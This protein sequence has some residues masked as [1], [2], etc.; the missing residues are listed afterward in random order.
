MSEVAVK[1][2][3]FERAKRRA[4]PSSNPNAAFNAALAAAR[5]EFPD[6]PKTRVAEIRM[7]NGGKYS[8]KYADLADVFNAINPVLAANGLSVWQEPQGLEIVTTIL[9]ESGTE[10]S[11]KWPIKAMPQRGLDDAQSFQSAVQVAKRYA[12]TATLGIT[13]E[14]TVEGDPMAKRRKV[15]VELDD[16]FQTVDGV[17]FPQGGKYDPKKTARQ[18]AEEA[19]RAIIALFADPKTQ[20]G[21]NGVWNRN[22]VFVEKMR[23]N[24]PDLYN[25]VFEAYQE[26]MALRSDDPEAANGFTMGQG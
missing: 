23:D 9:H 15:D 10:R 26:A 13:T 12:L 25:E 19:A 16:N 6:I 5:G 8:Y 22:E 3:D 14:E 1:P 21:I 7:K 17:R 24:H 20:V 2:I 18:N 4:T 11:T